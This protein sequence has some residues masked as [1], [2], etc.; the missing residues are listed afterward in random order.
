MS[1]D[2]AA[3][4]RTCSLTSK[5]YVSVRGSEVLVFLAADKHW[6]SEAGRLNCEIETDGRG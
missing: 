2:V 3:D 1:D 6:R 4:T 5:H